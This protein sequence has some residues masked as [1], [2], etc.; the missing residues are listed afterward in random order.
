[1][2]NQHLKSLLIIEKQVVWCN[3]YTPDKHFPY[4]KDRRY[5]LRKPLC[6]RG[7]AAFLQC[8]AGAQ[9]TTVETRITQA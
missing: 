7:V 3:T 4:K 5:S 6:F 8:A 2:L 1:M 9:G